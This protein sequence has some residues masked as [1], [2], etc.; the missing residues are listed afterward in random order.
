MEYGFGLIG[1]G[2]ISSTHAQAIQRVA[3]AR[4]AAVCDIVEEKARA[5]AEKYGAVPYLDYRE[6]LARDDVQVVNI[7]T[8][9]GTHAD[10]GIAAARAGKHVIITKPIDINL[11]KIDKLIATCRQHGV[12]LGATHQ[13]RSYGSYLRL[14]RAIEE[15]RLGRI[16]FGHAFVPWWRGQ[17]YYDSAEWRGTWRLDGG[18][19]LMNQGVHWVDL[20]QWLVGPVAQVQAYT[21]TFAHQIEVEDAAVAAV[22]FTSGALGLIMGSTVTY[23]GRPTR[24]EV[25]G[26]KGNV[27]IDGDVITHW[28]V[29]DEEQTGTAAAET[30][31]ADPMAG[32]ANAVDAHVAQITDVLRAVEE[33]R[34]PALSGQEARAAVAVVLAIY[35]S[36]RTGGPAVPG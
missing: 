27:I 33:N 11:D 18:G 15:G 28:Q 36:A 14:K 32:L 24:I 3:G 29:G 10:I 12:K 16:Y 34:D 9:S 19:C 23:K 8:W 4:L 13:F 25:Q 5:A 7:A 30:S 2:G 21:D 31:A 22:R 6:L 26:E 1:C 17:N 35:D 20:I